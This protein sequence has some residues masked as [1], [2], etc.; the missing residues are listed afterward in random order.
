MRKSRAVSL[1]R[2][3]RRQFDKLCFIKFLAQASKKSLCYFNRS[4]SHGVGV[5]KDQAFQLR[6]AGARPISVQI[7]DLFSPYAYFSAH[8]R[9]NID[10]K[11]APDPR[12]HA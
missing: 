10:S 4:V 3:G 9:A 5:L 8:G 2:D 11:R 7:C 12:R 1:P 6:K